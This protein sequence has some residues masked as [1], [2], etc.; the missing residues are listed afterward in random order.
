MASIIG[1]DWK[2]PYCYHAQVIDSDRFEDDWTR[3]AVVAAEK[4]AIQELKS[5]RAPGEAE[6]SRLPPLRA[7][8]DKVVGPPA[9]V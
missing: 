2:C 1:T 4:K 9:S 6:E 3:L 8:L 7:L 5:L